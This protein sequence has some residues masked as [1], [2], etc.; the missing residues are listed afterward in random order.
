MRRIITTW[1]GTP[2]AWKRYQ[3]ELS[4]SIERVKEARERIKKQQEGAT[5]N[6][7][8]INEKRYDQE[9]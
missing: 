1:N 5:W 7:P 9:A 8:T 2:S 6:M 4:A 3:K